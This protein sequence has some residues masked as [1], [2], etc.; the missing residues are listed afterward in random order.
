MNDPLADP[1]AGISVRVTDL[2]SS[3][4]LL[5]EDD[6]GKPVLLIRR[7]QSFSSAVD[8]VQKTLETTK[9][10]AER[11]V[12]TYHP[13]ATEWG[14]QDADWLEDFSNEKTE[15]AKQ[16]QAPTGDEKPAAKSHLRVVPRWAITLVAAATALGVGYSMPKVSNQPKESSATGHTVVPIEARP[17]DSDAFKDFA[18]DG[19]MA[20]TPTG[21]LEARCVDVE[22]KVMYS[23][24]SLGSDWTEFSF[25]YDEGVHRIGLRVCS[26]AAAAKLWV[27]MEAS[28]AS[29]PNLTQF[30][31]YALWGTDSPRLREY[32]RLLEDQDGPY[33]LLMSPG[34]RPEGRF[35]GQ[36][37]AVVDDAVKQGVLRSPRV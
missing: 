21:Q 4:S 29:M 11:I 12:R 28:Q 22:G 25:T 23:Q 32:V 15:P 24:A 5:F 26:N 1:A 31:R 20:C 19:E 37:E 3:D 8:S 6:Q 27:T 34:D 36:V 9:E 30:G 33:T 7:Q 13:E 35:A 16:R 18:A 10:Q 17:Y 2:R 14:E